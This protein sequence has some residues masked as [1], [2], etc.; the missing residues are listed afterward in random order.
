MQRLDDGKKKL[1]VDFLDG[2]RTDS[3]AEEMV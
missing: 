1:K 2:D 3:A